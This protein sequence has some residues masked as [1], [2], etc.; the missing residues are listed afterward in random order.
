MAQRKIPVNLDHQLRSIIKER[1][2]ES[3]HVEK[4]TSEELELKIS[5]GSDINTP[6]K[7]DGQGTSSDDTQKIGNSY[8]C[9]EVKGN[10]K[11]VCGSKC[12]I[13][14]KCDG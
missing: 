8:P 2:L 10:K 9:L 5:F 1:P 3:W 12:L 11:Q 6:N 13:R 7:K 4:E 14:R